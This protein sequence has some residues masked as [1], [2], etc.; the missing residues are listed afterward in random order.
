VYG[1]ERM[2]LVEV[3]MTN[4]SESSLVDAR[5]LPVDRV[6]DVVNLVP[7]HRLHVARE[8]RLA[9]GKQRSQPELRHV[10]RHASVRFN[11]CLATWR[12]LRVTT[13]TKAGRE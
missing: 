1:F 11:T 5:S 10:S 12:K 4:C 6:R 2:S 8:L 13:W 9:T 7:S 3:D